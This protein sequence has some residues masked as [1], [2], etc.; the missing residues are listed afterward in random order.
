MFYYTTLIMINRVQSQLLIVICFINYFKNDEQGSVI[1]FNF[2][3]DEQGSKS[4]ASNNDEQG[5]E[6]HSI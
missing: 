2:T 4:Y 3:N 1:C 5:S 6:S